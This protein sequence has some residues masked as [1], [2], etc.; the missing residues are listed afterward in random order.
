MARLAPDDLPKSVIC[1][2]SKLY[3]LA[4]ALI[5]RIAALTS[6]IAAGNVAS[7]LSL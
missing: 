4:F 3:L 6:S 2:T 5:K 7:P 1:S